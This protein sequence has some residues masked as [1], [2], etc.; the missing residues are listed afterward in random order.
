MET[1]LL[2][3]GLFVLVATADYIR[4]ALQDHRYRY[5]SRE[6]YI[7]YILGIIATISLF[8]MELSSFFSGRWQT[9][10]VFTL[11]AFVAPLISS[12]ALQRN[13]VRV[14]LTILRTGKCFEPAYIFV[15]SKEVLFQQLLFLVLAVSVSREISH[16]FSAFLLYILIIAIIQIPLMLHVERFWKYLFGLGFI[17][18]ATIFYY[19]Y[20][21]LGMFWPAVYIHALFYAFIWLVLSDP[22]LE[23][24]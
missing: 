14:C 9:E 22:T 8:H 11:V 12:F 21:Q 19:T 1:I 3:A 4:Y 7:L 15:K 24:D 17:F 20:I 10:V 2:A 13:Q 18:I 5:V 16:D 23:N 6:T